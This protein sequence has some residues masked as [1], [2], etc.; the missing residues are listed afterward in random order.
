VGDG[1]AYG[2]QKIVTNFTGGATLLERA[3]ITA[4]NVSPANYDDQRGMFTC[5]LRAKMGSAGTTRVR[6]NSG[7]YS[8]TFANSYFINPRV[9]ITDLNWRLY[10]MGL[11]RIPPI[12]QKASIGNI[13]MI[14]SGV[15]IEAERIL[16]TSNLEMDCLIMIPYN[17]SYVKL[18]FETNTSIGFVLRVNPDETMNAQGGSFQQSS[19]EP[20]NYGMPANNEAPLMVLAAQDT[21]AHSLSATAQLSLLYIRRWRSLRGIE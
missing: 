9:T 17:D 7:F 18:D 8:A 6:V 15:G 14:I 4:F 19:I 21:V 10:D 2:A 3:R 1:T 11:V 5:I 13:E 12:K 16:G 20:A